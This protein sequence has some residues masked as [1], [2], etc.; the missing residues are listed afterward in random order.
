M[1]IK[2]NY[3]VILSVF[4]LFTL[5]LYST[6]AMFSAS[7]ETSDF[8]NLSASSLPTETQMLE[9]ER[10]SLSANEIKTIDFNINNNTTSNLYYGAWYEMIEPSSINENI[11]VAKHADS[12]AETFGL[13]DANNSKK[14]TL[15][16]SNQTN[17]SVTLNIGVAYSKTSSLNLPTN[18]NIISEEYAPCKVE[19]ITKDT[20]GA[21][22]PKLADNMIPVVYDNC[23]GVWKKADTNSWYNYTNKQWANAVLVS[24]TNR[25]TY[26]SAEAGTVVSEDDILAHYVWIPRYK[27]KVW[28]ITKTIGSDSYDAK[29]SGID[30][31]FEQGTASTG[32]IKCNYNFAVT[33]GSLSETCNGSN[34]QYYTHPAFTFGSA[35]LSGIWVGK[36][37]LSGSASQIAIKPNEK[38]LTNQTPDSFYSIVRSM[39]NSGNAY[40]LSTNANVVDTHMMKNLEWGAV[41]YLTHSDYGRCSNGSCSEV[42]INNSSSRTTGCGAL[43]SS[44]ENATC[45][46]YNTEVGMNAST[47]GNIYGVYDMSGGTAEYVM[48]N[49]SQKAGSY[50]YRVLGAGNNFTYNSSTAKYIDTYAYGNDMYRQPAYNL[51]RLGDAVGEVVLTEG[52]ISRNK[53]MW[54][55]DEVIFLFSFGPWPIRGNF[56]ESTDGAG[57][58]SLLGADGN[59]GEYGSRATLAVY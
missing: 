39:Q 24:S 29:N 32:E 45:N 34:G 1:E 51:T 43:P 50:V 12:E 56:S 4:G 55:N 16:I 28:N 46:A 7:V 21:N 18:R 27:Y 23:E 31:V 40:G 20:S 38:S 41:A 30:I 49:Q 26:L 15:V 5:A 44:S 10:I 57:I 13:I 11:I 37:E 47:T 9:Y 35:E 17:S 22:A 58:F 48:A 25:S 36:F 52:G 59:A 14:V 6:Y 54:Y 8:V 2:K 53:T 33:D 3:L 42:G 19:E